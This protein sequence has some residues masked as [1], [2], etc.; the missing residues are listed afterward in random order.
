M[1]IFFLKS[2]PLLWNNPTNS[3]L[4]SRDV[5]LGTCT[6]T[7]VVGLLKYHFKVLVLVLEGQVLVDMWQVLH[8][9]FLIFQQT[10]EK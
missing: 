7:R 3:K 9:Y 5:V 10:V 2:L 4:P 6:C 1:G 8:F